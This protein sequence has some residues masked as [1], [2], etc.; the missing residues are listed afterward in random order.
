[1]GFAPLFY[2]LF[3]GLGAAF[4]LTPSTLKTLETD[5]GFVLFG[6]E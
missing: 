6:L 3:G 4:K 5:W 1:M 2:L